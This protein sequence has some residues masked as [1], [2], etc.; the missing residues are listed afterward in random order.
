MPGYEYPANGSPGDRG[1]DDAVITGSY[2]PLAATTDESGRGWRPRIA[3]Q[4]FDG[5]LQAPSTLRIKLAELSD[6]GRG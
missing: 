5:G 2:S 6:S 4:Q 3:G 1:I